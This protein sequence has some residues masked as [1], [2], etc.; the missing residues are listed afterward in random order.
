MIVKSITRPIK[1]S[2]NWTR[3]KGAG[4]HL[5]KTAGKD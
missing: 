4:L 3:D 5:E 1:Y 2:Y